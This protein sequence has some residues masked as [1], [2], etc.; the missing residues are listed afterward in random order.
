[1]KYFYISTKGTKKN[2]NQDFM[3]IEP[4][5]SISFFAVCD[6]LGG[7]KGG[8]IAS[9]MCAN[10]LN[11]K[12]SKIANFTNSKTLLPNILKQINTEI[13]TY[14]KTHEDCN[15]MGTT[16]VACVIIK[17]KAYIV[18]VGDSRLYLFKNEKLKQITE[19]NSKVWDLFKKGLIKKEEIVD[20]PIKHL[21]TK[22]VGTK[23]SVKPDFYEIELSKKDIL[24]LC[25]DGLTD[26]TI[27]DEIEEILN[28]NKL[29]NVCD[30]LVAKAKSNKTK[31]DVSIITI[32][33]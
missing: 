3:L 7:H 10:L 1:M 26:V 15:N 27:D 24:V 33:I 32:Q 18:N 6:G 9:K 8:E 22:A 12:L 21:I 20:S 31:D 14:A 19:D 28:N 23:K 2:V 29:D 11:K 30:L 17:N 5:E 16:C 4:G 25:S 13:Y